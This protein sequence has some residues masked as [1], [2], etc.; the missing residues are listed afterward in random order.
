[1]S[2]Q[3][4][5]RGASGKVYGLILTRNDG[6]QEAKGANGKLLGIYNPQ[7]NETQM[8][9]PTIRVMGSGN[10]LGTLFGNVI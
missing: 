6:I 8:S 9:Y 7:R 1:M 10:L 5:I 2:S 4:M 3:Q